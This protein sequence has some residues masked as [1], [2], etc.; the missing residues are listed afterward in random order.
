[1]KPDTSA[2]RITT[3]SFCRLKTQ[4]ALPTAK[5]PEPKA[6]SVI[7]LKVFQIPQAYTSFVPEKRP[8]GEKNRTVARIKPSAATAAKKRKVGVTTGSRYTGTPRCQ[9]LRRVVP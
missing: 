3:C 9:R 2:V 7:T 6:V 8:S 1:M 4:A 5:G